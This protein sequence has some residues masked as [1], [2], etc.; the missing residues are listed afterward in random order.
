M[1]R[2]NIHFN[3]NCCFDVSLQLKNEVANF[4]SGSLVV[5]YVSSIALG[6]FNT[7]S[8]S[9][10]PMI[11]GH[12]ALLAYFLYNY[13]I[14]LKSNSSGSGSINSVSGVTEK[15]INDLSLVSVKVFYK[16]IWNLFYL[17]YC[18]YPF[19]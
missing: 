14:L 1:V 8:F 9:P 12:L 16:S 2:V 19:I 11:G 18:L 17:E 7:K 15:Q 6:A 5:G 10:L 3:I 13:N 4:A